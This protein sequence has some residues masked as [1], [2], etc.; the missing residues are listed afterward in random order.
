MLNIVCVRVG[1]KYPRDYV[2]ILHDMVRRN[3]DAPFKFWCVT[4]DDRIIHPEINIIPHSPGL[5]GWWQKIALFGPDMPWTKGERVVYFDL[6]VAIVGRLEELFETKGIVRDWHVPGYNSSV[7]AWDHGEHAKVWILF[8]PGVMN[9]L[10]GDQDWIYKVAMG[11]AMPCDPWE[12]FPRDWCVSYRSHAQDF[13]PHGTKVVCFHGEP[14]PAACG[15]WVR[16]VWKIGGLTEMPV[17]TNMNVSLDLALSN[18]RVN[19]K[20]DIPWFV[21]DEPHNET[22]V[23]VA[24]GPSL[25]KSI[26][27]IKNH[28]KRGAK[29]LALNNTATYLNTHGITPDL[30]VMVDARP[31]NIVFARGTAKRYLIASQCDPAVF[32]A[33]KDRDTHLWHAAICDEVRDVLE[34]YW[35]S[36]PCVA[37]G[38]GGTVGLRTINLCIVSGYRKLHLYGFDSCYTAEQHHAYKQSLN[39][40]ENVVEVYVPMLD[41]T[42]LCAVWMS[43]QATEFR[44]LVGPAIKANNVSLWVHG[45][46]LI[47]DM[48]RAMKC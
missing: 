25:A 47:P 46:G 6:D 17:S 37:I 13:P 9:E 15:G 35:E 33:L 43:R 44:D 39:D 18:M 10:P 3:L 30:L 29:I 5:L 7:M 28:Q 1:D 48:W 16:D 45:A 23:I 40:H 12:L 2:A 31:E 36:K 21:G 11:R 38:G 26:Q 14:K 20:R 8:R 41:K 34:P 22:A 19:A 24:G 42:Y 32:D 4:D 27:A